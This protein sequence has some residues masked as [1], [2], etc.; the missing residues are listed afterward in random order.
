MHRK[1]NFCVSFTGTIHI[2]IVRICHF[3]CVCVFFFLFLFSS[4]SFQSMV[5]CLSRVKRWS[6]PPCQPYP[7]G[8]V[9]LVIS[10]A[11]LRQRKGCSNSPTYTFLPPLPP[12]PPDPLPTGRPT[13][14][15]RSTVNNPLL[16]PCGC[17]CLLG[18]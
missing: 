7:A 13:V 3:W 6:Y 10:A 2:R 11:T 5:A 16:P 14:H 1:T 9:L 15:R 17:G 18:T 8:C 4:F 12:R